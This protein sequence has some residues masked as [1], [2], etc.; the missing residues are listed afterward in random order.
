MPQRVDLVHTTQLGV[1]VY[2]ERP[3]KKGD[4]DFIVSHAPAD[5]NRRE[6]SHAELIVDLY[7]KRLAVPEAG[8]DLVD[9]FLSIIGNVQGVKDRREVPA[10][11]R[12][13]LEHVN[14]FRRM[15]LVDAGGYA[16]ELLLVVFEL[17]QIQEKTNYSTGTVPRNLFELIRRQPNDLMTISNLTIFGY[18]EPRLRYAPRHVKE[19]HDLVDKYRQRDGLLRSLFDLVLRP[20]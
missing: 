7:R 19:F 11:R 17:I 14:H 20:R 18:R 2:V 12:F 15:G 16:L 5:G 3:G 8:N 9:H 6:T 1:E 13:S 4:R 10:L